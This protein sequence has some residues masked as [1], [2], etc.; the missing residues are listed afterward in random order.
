MAVSLSSSWRCF[1]SSFLLKSLS[2]SLRISWISAVASSVWALVPFT[3]IRHMPSI[4]SFLFSVVIA[5]CCFSLVL[6]VVKY[7]DSVDSNL[8]LS[9]AV[10]MSCLGLVMGGIC[11]T[12][13]LGPSLLIVLAASD[14]LWNASLPLLSLLPLLPLMSLVPCTMITMFWS[15]M[16]SR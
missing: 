15:L 10:S 8:V 2:A 11:V 12:S 16:M 7:F 4:P 3:A 9:T 13:T 14:R 5:T 6:M 1:C